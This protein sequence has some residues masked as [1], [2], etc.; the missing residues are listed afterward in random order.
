MK[1]IPA[2]EAD[3]KGKLL[4]ALFSTYQTEYAK[5]GNSNTWLCVLVKKLDELCVYKHFEALS[6]RRGRKCKMLP[7]WQNI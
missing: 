2:A 1:V 4:N 5:N 7:I 3:W 6:C